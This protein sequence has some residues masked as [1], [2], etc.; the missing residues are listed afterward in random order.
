MFSM[1]RM[2]VGIAIYMA[3]LLG[4]IFLVL[5]QSPL[6]FIVLLFVGVAA[7]LVVTYTGW[8]TTPGDYRRLMAQ[9]VDADA[10]ILEMKDTGVTVNN[11]PYVNL[12]LR[13]QPPGQ[14][15]YET[16]VRMLVSRIAFPSVGDT[17]RV[18]Y[19]PAKPQDVIVP[20]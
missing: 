12:R 9:G 6:L 17:I 4:I 2:L 20:Q 13:V 1:T 19:D 3:Y 10:Q 5:P 16:K 15:A 8:L 7:L 18:K 14:P 11:N